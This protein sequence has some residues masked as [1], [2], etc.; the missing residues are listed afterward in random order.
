MGLLWP[1]VGCGDGDVCMRSACAG[2][3]SA[4][5]NVAARLRAQE[6]VMT[7]RQTRARISRAMRNTMAAV[8]RA[9]VAEVEAAVAAM[10]ASRTRGLMRDMEREWSL[11]AFTRGG[12]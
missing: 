9:R 6:S 2:G 1:Y 7:P 4:V 10:A 8:S 5:E 11:R 12:R 3:Y